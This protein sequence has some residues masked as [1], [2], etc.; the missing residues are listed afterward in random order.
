MG[1]QDLS[2]MGAELGVRMLCHNGR[3]VPAIAA[4]CLIWGNRSS[5]SGNQFSQVYRSVT[6]N[7]S[8]FPS[9]VQSS[10]DVS[11]CIVHNGPET[12]PMSGA[13]PS[14]TV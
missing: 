2:V 12:Y 5:Q 11:V 3:R 13:S 4:A 14:Q 9:C 8:V 7:I 6:F 10:T 1:T